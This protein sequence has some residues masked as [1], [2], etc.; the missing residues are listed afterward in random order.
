MVFTNSFT[1]RTQC[2]RNMVHHI[3]FQLIYAVFHL[4]VNPKLV[5]KIQNP[6]R[7]RLKSL[8][9]RNAFICFCWRGKPVSD[10][11]FVFPLPLLLFDKVFFPYLV[12]LANN[13]YFRG[14]L[15]ANMQRDCWTFLSLCIFQLW[16]LVFMLYFRGGI[17]LCFKPSF[18]GY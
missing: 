14:V 3:L 7:W 2:F 12:F 6:W 15:I 17:W 8:Y 13:G 16:L 4:S 10:M 11:I 9:Q 1:Y 18:F 5:K